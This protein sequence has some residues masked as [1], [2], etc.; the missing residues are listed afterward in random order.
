MKRTSYPVKGSGLHAAKLRKLRAARG[1]TQQDVAVAIDAT[2]GSYV[3]WESGY[4]QPRMC[5][6]KALAKHFGVTIE[7]LLD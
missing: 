5:F 1:M 6:L 4:C 3:R 2:L 7:E